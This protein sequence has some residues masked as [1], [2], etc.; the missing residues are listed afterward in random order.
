MNWLEFR[1]DST[2]EFVE[3][4]VETLMKFA[5]G[6]VSIENQ[7]TYNPDEGETLNTELPVTIKAFLP[8]DSAAPKSQGEIDLRIR[9]ISLTSNSIG[10]LK[11]SEIEEEDWEDAWKKNFNVLRVGKNIIIRPTWKKFIPQKTDIVINLDPG[12]AFGT[13]HHQ[14]TRMCMVA[15]EKFMSRGMNVLDVGSGSGILSITAAKLG[16]AAVH[17]IDIDSVAEKVASENTIINNVQ[18]IIHIY[19][20]TLETS[21]IADAFFDLIVANISAKVISGLSDSFSNK[22]LPNGRLIVSGIL[23]KDVAQIKNKLTQKNFALEN[24]L[25]DGD[26]ALLSFRKD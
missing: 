10:P 5:H 15:L 9:L 21:T 25:T 19:S 23:T 17:A 13:G 2:P 24:T 4:I 11:I 12:M 7:T 26:W 8:N 18:H 3:P 22:L 6:G 20:G 14:T 1:I 16:A